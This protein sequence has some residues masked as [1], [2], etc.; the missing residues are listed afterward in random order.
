MQTERW[1][2]GTV[3]NCTVDRIPPNQRNTEIMIFWSRVRSLACQIQGRETSHK[4]FR[5]VIKKMNMKGISCGYTPNGM[6]PR[7]ISTTSSTTVLLCEQKNLK[8]KKSNDELHGANDKNLFTTPRLFCYVCIHLC[9]YISIAVFGFWINRHWGTRTRGPC[10]ALDN[11]QRM[12]KKIK[13]RNR[14]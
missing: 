10:A 8:A 13:W 2:V 14:K 5:K 3:Q 7:I 4:Y 12:Q 11:I 6:L 1:S 9:M